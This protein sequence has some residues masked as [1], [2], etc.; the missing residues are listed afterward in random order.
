MKYQTSTLINLLENRVERQIAFSV[1]SLQN[2]P[3]TELTTEPPLGGWNV[4][5]ILDHLNSYNY[6]YLPL[7]KSAVN[8]PTKEIGTEFESGLLG[9]YFSKMIHP[10]TGTKKIRAA[11]QHLPKLTGDPQSVVREFIQHQETLLQYLFQARTVDLA[12]A[13]IPISIAKVIRLKLG[14]ILIFFINH[15][16]RHLIQVSKLLATREHYSVLD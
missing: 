3:D 7:L 5:Q 2:L 6:Y 1:R 10:T 14:D 4:V 13:R 12:K 9:D 16:D 8:S 15:T 11:K